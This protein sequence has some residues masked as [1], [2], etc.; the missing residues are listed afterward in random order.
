MI[1]YDP[2]GILEPIYPPTQRSRELYESDHLELASRR[3]SLAPEAT[4]FFSHFLD[5]RFVNAAR[6]LAHLWLK[7]RD[8]KK[9]NWSAGIRR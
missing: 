6:T 3:P 2:A 5:G 9:A 1:E 8:Q 4:L 7:S